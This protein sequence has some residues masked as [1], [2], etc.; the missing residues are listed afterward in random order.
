MSFMQ[1]LFGSEA[2]Q[3]QTGQTG[4]QIGQAGQ[5][6]GEGRD[7]AESQ[8]AQVVDDGHQIQQGI[9]Q[10]QVTIEATGH[11]QNQAQIQNQVTQQGG[12]NQSAQAT[13]QQA[14]EHFVELT[15]LKVANTVPAAECFNDPGQRLISNRLG[16]E[17]L[18][19]AIA[20]GKTAIMSW[21]GRISD[22]Y[23]KWWITLT[24]SS[25]A[26]KARVE[27]FKQ[28]LGSAANFKETVVNNGLGDKIKVNGVVTASKIAE[29]FEKAV[30]FIEAVNK[31]ATDIDAAPQTD[32]KSLQTDAPSDEQR[33][34]SLN[35][36]AKTL[37]AKAIEGFTAA[38]GA[39]E[40]RYSSPEFPGNKALVAVTKT[41][42]NDVDTFEKMKYAILPFNP[43]ASP[44]SDHEIPGCDQASAERIAGAL[45]KF[46]DHLAAHRDLAA[47]SKQ[48]HAAAIKMIDQTTGESPEKS[49]ASAGDATEVL[50]R[51]ICKLGKDLAVNAN[52]LGITTA[53]NL[54]HYIESSIGAAAQ[55]TSQTSQISQQTAQ[56]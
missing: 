15:G 12:G 46:T 20:R 39:G 38:R 45:I 40:N 44:I 14:V 49:V 8:V 29:A 16:V 24:S 23:D 3:D 55:Q 11:L 54:V 47:K 26:V 9:N 10:V 22:W 30:A 52:K 50:V 5:Q 21:L 51:A 7:S 35:G 4:Q 13:M 27:K 28:R 34:E 48:Y 25:K 56:A 37:F 18:N 19:N 33:L 1:S 41:G 43:S 2:F 6:A 53:M 31:N 17:A 36:L 42:E 32:A